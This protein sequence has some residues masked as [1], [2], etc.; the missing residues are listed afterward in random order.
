MTV[1]KLGSELHYIKRIPRVLPVGEVLVHNRVVPQRPLG[2]NGFRAWTQKPSDSLK[3]HA[4][5]R[6]A[7]PRMD[8]RDGRGKVPR[9]RAKK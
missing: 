8:M 9:F 1:A 7:G 6:V 4:H 3:G 5:H 2:L